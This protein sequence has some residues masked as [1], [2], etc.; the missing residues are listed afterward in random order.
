MFGMLS[1]SSVANAVTVGSLTI[2][3]MIRVGYKR[4]FAGAVEAAASTGGQITPPVLGAAAFLMI[5]FLNVSYQT[6]IAAAIVPAFMHFFGVFMQV[7]FEAKRYGLRG[8]TEEEMPRL[9]E[10]LRQR[11]P[12][13]IPLVLLIWILVS[14][15]TPYLAAFTGITSCMIVGLT[16]QVQR[17]RP[18]E[19]GAAGGAAPDCWPPF[20]LATWA[21]TANGS[22]WASLPW[23]C[24]M[25]LAGWKLAG[26]TG[27]IPHRCWWRR[28]KPAPST[29]WPWA[30]RRPR[31]AS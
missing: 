20:R 6:I 22:S 4:E 29:R 1:G 5:E 18:P 24:A 11:W 26:V 31:W 7:H 23:A 9:R 12:T 8:L 17:Q 27:R 16:T 25:A 13:L 28:L 2:P 30:P 15:R 14:G 21:T 3:A 10:S 19:L